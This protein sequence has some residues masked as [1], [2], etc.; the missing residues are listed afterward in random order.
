MYVSES[1][2]R[3]RDCESNWKTW[4]WRVGLKESINMKD[5]S[6]QGCMCESSYVQPFPGSG[7]ILNNTSLGLA[8][9]ISDRAS[10]RCSGGV[11]DEYKWNGV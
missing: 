1:G 10:R 6:M 3:G 9:R 8:S 11:W 7:I 2:R 4:G 5:K